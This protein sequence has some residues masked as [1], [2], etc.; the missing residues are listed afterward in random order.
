MTQNIVSKISL[1]TRNYIVFNNYN[2][3]PTYEDIKK[4]LELFKMSRAN[5]IIAIGGGSTIDTAKCIKAY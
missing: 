4:G 2:P 5:T 1:I 3:N